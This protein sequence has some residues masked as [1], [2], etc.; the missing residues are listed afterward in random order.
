M[1]RHHAQS[2]FIIV[3]IRYVFVERHPRGRARGVE[4]RKLIK[5]LDPILFSD[6]AIAACRSP[7]AGSVTSRGLNGGNRFETQC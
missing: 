6:V 2:R 1:I 3:Y 5:R 7:I 4:Y